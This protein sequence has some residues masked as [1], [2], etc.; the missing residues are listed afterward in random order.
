MNKMH[1]KQ[2]LE[3]AM[4]RIMYCREL[5]E[6]YMTCLTYLRRKD[7]DFSVAGDSI[8]TALMQSELEE[9]RNLLIWGIT[10]DHN[11]VDRIKAAVHERFLAE[12][13]HVAS[14]F[15]NGETPSGWLTSDEKEFREMAKK[16]FAPKEG[17]QD[18]RA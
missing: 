15:H 18:E 12:R 10:C 16:A 9:W 6:N 7:R 3:E 13:M 2:I 14:W 4:E 8:Y 5:Q 11:T 1:K 17:G